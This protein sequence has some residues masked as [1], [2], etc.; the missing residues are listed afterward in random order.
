MQG[1]TS[2]ARTERIET[3]EPRFESG[4]VKAKMIID[5]ISKSFAKDGDRL[6]VIDLHDLHRRRR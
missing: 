2:L 1:R 3:P 4:R 6:L 5:G